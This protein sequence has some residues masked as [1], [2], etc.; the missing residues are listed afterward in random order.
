MKT[1]LY[2]DTETT[3]LNSKKHSPIQ[4]GA[5]IERDNVII[6]EFSYNC[7]PIDYNFVESGALAVNRT[8][9]EEIRTFSSPREVM[10]KVINHLKQH[11]PKGDKY[12]MI[13]QNPKFDIDMMNDACSRLCSPYMFYEFIDS[14]AIDTIVLTQTLVARGLTDKPQSFKLASLASHFGIKTGE[15]H[16]AL[17][18]V[19]ATRDI[20]KFILDS[21][22]KSPQELLNSIGG[23]SLK[24]S[25]NHTDFKRV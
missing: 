16:D 22:I 15:L 4:I 23:E 24:Q 3:G 25:L 6:D 7:Q 1:L 9:L 11:L 21:Y 10:A 14:M 19:R 12:I 20:F 17:A 8:T 18:D 13:G 2:L 5:I